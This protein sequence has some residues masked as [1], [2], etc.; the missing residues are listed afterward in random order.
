M[1]TG[2]LAITLVLFVFA[3]AAFLR[4]KGQSAADAAALAAAMEA[5][6]RLYEDF[7]EALDGEG[8]LGDV[9]AGEGLDAGDDEAACEAAAEL[10]GSNDADVASCGPIGGGA[11]YTVA[12]VTQDTLGDTAVPGTENQKA[13][14]G[15][16][17][18]FEGRCEV[19]D[20]GDD[21]VE[22]SCDDDEELS[23]DPGDEDEL[24]EA[25]ELFQVY[26]DDLED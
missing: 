2:L 23:F 12:I 1:V 6:D 20:E 13:N 15:A 21:E 7:L 22:L 26:L 4:N 24:P 25:R 10:A 3:Q 11:G 5:R 17:A 14:A 9:L 8:D 19:E 16:T 18:V